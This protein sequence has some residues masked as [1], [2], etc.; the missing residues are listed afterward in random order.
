VRRQIINL[1][2]LV[3]GMLCIIYYFVC[4]FGT[5]FGQS[6]L[7]VW[8]AAGA[9]LIA[10]FAIVQVSIKR[11]QP[12]PYPGWAVAAAKFAFVILLS[13][14][15]AIECFVAS[16][17][18]NDCPAG[19]DYVIILGAKT[20]SVTI[21]ARMDRAYEYLEENP[22][23]MVVVTGGKGADETMSE[24][25][26][27]RMGLIRRGIDS[28]RIIVENK[29]TSTAEN[30]EFSRKL[31]GDSDAS[32]AVVTNNYHVFRSVGIAKKNFSG[33]VYGL[34]MDSNPISLPHYMV[35]EFFAVTVDFIRGN[36][37]Y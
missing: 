27:M 36:I 13:V 30:L 1:M 6:M 17:F 12:L 35:R 4:G 25:D 7:W 16:G 21:E 15:V 24:G 14:F 28:S 26:Y 20:G 23:T 31:I 18:E 3:A 10:R 29:S 32:V 2:F 5:T 33:D 11:G 19:V 8:P 22:G 37:A 9:V 34:P